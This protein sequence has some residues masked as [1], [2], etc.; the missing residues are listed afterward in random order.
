MK[1][2]VFNG[3][4]RGESSN[5]KILL[6]Q[7]LEGFQAAGH[8]DET[9]SLKNIKEHPKYAE[10]FFEVDAVLLAFPLYTDAMPGIVKA[11]IDE[12]SLHRVPAG[13]ETV[14]PK[15]IIFLVHSGFPEAKHSALIAAY[16]VKLA[17]RLNYECP[18]VMIKGGSEGIQQLPEKATKKLFGQLY[19]LGLCYGQTGKLDPHLLKELRGMEKIPPVMLPVLWIFKAFGLFDREWNR[20]LKENGAFEKRFDQPYK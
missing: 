13:V 15:S 8:T 20:E 17:K 18:G 9:H 3:S 19:Q 14:A 6:E 12:L 11:F 5:T 2:V 10:L 4:P 7:F 16:L 1:L